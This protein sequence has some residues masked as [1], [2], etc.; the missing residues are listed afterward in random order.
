MHDIVQLD[1]KEGLKNA[2]VQKFG[3][4]YLRIGFLSVYAKQ[5]KLPE[6]ELKEDYSLVHSQSDIK[7]SLMIYLSHA[8][9]LIG[10]DE[11]GLGLF[12]STKMDGKTSDPYFIFIMNDKLQ[13]KSSVKKKTVN[14]IYG[15]ILSFDNIS[16]DFWN[17]GYLKVLIYDHDKLLN[18]DDFLGEFTV[19]LD[20]V[21]KN[22][23]KWGVSQH[24]IVNGS[25]ED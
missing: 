10:K 11:K 18:A 8:K 5:P 4:I 20:P 23:N 12:K 3:S 2:Q 9:G 19:D 6:E 17:S 7:G 14:P 1:N 13:K 15:E 21:A 25:K 22:L 24:F 16:L